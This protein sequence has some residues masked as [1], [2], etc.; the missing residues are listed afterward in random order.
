MHGHMNVK[1]RILF[2]LYW[3]VSIPVSRMAM[4]VLLFYVS[5]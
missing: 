5:F 2:R 3:S 4:I 1:I